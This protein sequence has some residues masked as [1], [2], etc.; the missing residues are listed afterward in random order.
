MNKRYNA[1]KTNNAHNVYHYHY[2][3]SLGLVLE[4]QIPENVVD[5]MKEAL[6]NLLNLPDNSSRIN[7][8]MEEE[9]SVYLSNSI[10]SCSTSN[11][12]TNY[13]NKVLYK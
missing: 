11:R 7:M 5:Q 8:V 9:A 3:V 10:I 1:H 12:A 6:V 13:G 2:H 4:A